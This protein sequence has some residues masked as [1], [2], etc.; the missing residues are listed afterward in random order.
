MFDY[1]KQLEAFHADRVV[2]PKK[3]QDMLLEHRRA[4]RD[5]LVS[6]L[7]DHIPGA[8]ISTGNFRPQG[9][10]AVK[11]IVQTRFTDEEYDIDDG[12]VI[13]L[14]KLV[15]EAGAALSAEHVREQVRRALEDKRFKRQP[16]LMSNCVRVF[17][18][19]E[20]ALKHHVDFPVYRERADGE[21]TIRELAGENGWVE[22]D[23]TQVNS[24]FQQEVEGRNRQVAG[25]G[26]QMRVLIR[27]LKRFC[28]SRE[29]WL[30]AHPNGMKLTMLVAEC[31]P[32]YSSRL[33]V[34]A[35]G[36]L[37]NL[38]SRLKREKTIPNLA[39]PDAPPL[40]R[41]RRDE[42]VIA[43]LEHVTQAL[44]QLAKLD[45]IERERDAREVW[46]WLFQSDGYLEEREVARKDASRAARLPR[47]GPSVPWA[48]PIPWPCTP[49]HSV[50]VR[51][52]L[53]TS[54]YGWRQF[55][56]GDPLPKQRDLRFEPITDARGAYDV[57]WQV[58]N[59]GDEASRAGALR[60]EIVPGNGDRRRIRSE[61]TAYTGR[62]WVECFI[63]QGGVCV[64]RSGPFFVAIG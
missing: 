2:L 54:T 56:S 62:H 63:V 38:E 58:V 57:F 35:R 20:D 34:A 4:N 46:D 45:D 32:D 1:S 19:D 16:E 52:Q 22:S 18:A 61:A 43:L 42:N 6:R 14:S 12:L 23:P 51:G 13:P 60:G 44:E 47:T 31:Q 50:H 5:R 36:L 10:M 55:Q 24:W 41:T 29:D 37:A 28:R 30:D 3:L 9:S 17:Y 26:T 21:N 49:R 48:R 25:R 40:T 7:P 64:A 39:H 11:T 33:D 53:S 27:L 59:T 8:S 15:D